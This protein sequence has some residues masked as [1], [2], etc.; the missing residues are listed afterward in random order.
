[1]NREEE[2]LKFSAI[3][4]DRVKKMEYGEMSVT[5]I[6]KDGVPMLPTLNIV[7]RTRI[8]YPVRTI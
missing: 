7:K 8:R 4:E 5:I 6:L 1:M 3:L 2:L